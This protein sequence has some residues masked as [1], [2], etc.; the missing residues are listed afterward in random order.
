MRSKSQLNKRHVSNIRPSKQKAKKQRKNKNKNKNKKGKKPKNNNPQAKELKEMKKLLK[1]HKQDRMEST[2]FD[3]MVDEQ[4]KIMNNLSKL[5]SKT[6]SKYY[7]DGFHKA[8]DTHPTEDKKADYTVVLPFGQSITVEAK[9]K[10]KEISERKKSK[11]KHYPART[12]SK[13]KSNQI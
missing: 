11:T 3:K 5:Q 1:E 13:K 6:F 4:Q 9:G 7:V 2:E 8:Y 10:N 12:T